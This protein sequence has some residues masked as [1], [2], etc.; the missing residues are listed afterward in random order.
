MKPVKNLQ[1]KIENAKMGN[2]NHTFNLDDGAVEYFEFTLFGKKYKFRYPNTE[3]FEIISKLKENEDDK[4]LQDFLYP[5][6]TPIDD[7]APDFKEAEK[8]MLPPHLRNFNEMVMEEFRAT[9]ASS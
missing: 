4:G 8:K 7:D 3:E 2:H 9:K 5:F 6:I 1:E